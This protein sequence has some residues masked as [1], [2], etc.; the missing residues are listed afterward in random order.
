MTS[1]LKRAAAGLFAAAAVGAAAFV[2]GSATA[3]ASPVPA[4]HET[5][6]ANPVFGTAAFSQCFGPNV[7][8]RVHVTCWAWWAPWTTYERYGPHVWGGGQSWTSCDVPFTLRSWHV[9]ARHI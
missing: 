4:A 5:C 1:P 3:T 7:V 6:S 2:G 9:D 8:H